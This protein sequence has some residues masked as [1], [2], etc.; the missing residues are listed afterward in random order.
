[1]TKFAPIQRSKRI[2]FFVID[3]VLRLILQNL[4]D[5]CTNFFIWK[6]III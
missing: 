1:M 4:I 2:A 6:Y 3:I 5:I